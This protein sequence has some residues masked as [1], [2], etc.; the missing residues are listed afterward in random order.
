MKTLL[1]RNSLLTFLAVFAAVAIHASAATYFWDADGA[2]SA[3]TGGNGTWDTTS[4]LWRL[5]TATGNLSAWP[6]SSADTANLAGT[7]GTVTIAASTTINA[8]VVQLQTNGYTLAS[9]SGGTLTLASALNVTSGTS[10][11]SATLAGAS[12][13]FNNG[14]TGTLL[15]AGNNTFNGK[16]TIFGGTVE[17]AALNNFGTGTAIDLSGGTLRWASGNTVDVSPR[18]VTIK[19]T[20]SAIDTNG[21]DVSFATTNKLVSAAGVNLNKAG[22]GNLTISSSSNTGYLGTTTV[23]MGTLVLGSANAIAASSGITVSGGKLDSSVANANLGNLT[24]SSG[25]LDVY[26][27][28]VGSL[29]LASGKNLSITG[30]TFEMNLASTSSY[31]QL[32][33]SGA[34]T[35]SITGGTLD[36]LNF[37]PDYT[38]SYTILSGFN[39]GAVSGLT[40]T[41]YDN[42]N[43]S[44]SLSN[45]GVLSFAVPEPG[46]FVS[47]LGGLGLLVLFR[48]WRRN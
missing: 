44:A 17:F 5:T 27:S 18:T 37:V 36:L 9:A 21:N 45:A 23:S 47:L 43:Y 6:N 31:D 2:G 1:P 16:A 40:F 41:N 7:A 11:V 32:K 20:G 4:S 10:T 12:V 25:V 19:G 29:T 48:R 34:G 22:S 42:L 3:A 26:G 14:T 8:F 13:L 46:T 38:A 24:L 28:S 15:L 33:G 35:F 30:G 39:S